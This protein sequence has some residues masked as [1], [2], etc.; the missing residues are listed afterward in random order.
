MCSSKRDMSDNS[1]RG[2]KKYNVSDL[3]Q[4]YSESN[5]INS[6]YFLIFT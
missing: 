6:A 4:S 3:Y 1:K 5:K 2:D